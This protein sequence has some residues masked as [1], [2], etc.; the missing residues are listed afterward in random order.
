M[1]K[2]NNKNELYHCCH[3]A[4]NKADKTVGGMELSGPSR[5][6]SFEATEL[7]VLAAAAS[8]LSVDKL[9]GFIT[10]EAF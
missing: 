9:L 8:K 2:L 4:E 3:L 10:T 7:V 6:A 1:K 5:I